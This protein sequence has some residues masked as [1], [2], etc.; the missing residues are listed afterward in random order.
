LKGEV[1]EG[2]EKRLI[3]SLL[4]PSPTKTYLAISIEPMNSDKYFTMGGVVEGE[5]LSEVQSRYGEPNR[6]YHN[7]SHI[8]RLLSLLRLHGEKIQDPLAVHLA[9]IFHE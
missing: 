6:R 1:R 8:E 4:L 7:S 2:E 5:F 9:I 3:F